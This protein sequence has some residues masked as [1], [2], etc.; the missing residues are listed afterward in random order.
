MEI[1]TTARLPSGTVHPLLA[2]LEGV[3]W[4]PSRWEAIDPRAQGRPVA[5]LG[6]SLARPAGVPF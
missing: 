2:R 3:G 5:A 4:L 6:A 1:G